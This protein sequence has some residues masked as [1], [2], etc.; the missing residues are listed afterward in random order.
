MQ[1]LRKSFLTSKWLLPVCFAIILIIYMLSISLETLFRIPA[2]RHAKTEETWCVSNQMQL[3][4]ALL[5]YQQDYDSRF[6]PAASWMDKT[7]AYTHNDSIYHC[8]SVSPKSQLKYG[9]AFNIALNHT[10]SSKISH[11]NSMPATYDSTNLARNATDAVASLPKPGRHSGCN[12]VGY[13]DGHV[14]SRRQIP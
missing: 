8:P 7:A 4:L 1:P 14:A 5:Q 11:L 9:Y 6:P 13:A 3:G 12:V 10:I 2:Y